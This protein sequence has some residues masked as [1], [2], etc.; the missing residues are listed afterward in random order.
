M[1][2]RQQ[3]TCDTQVMHREPLVRRL[4]SPEA[5][6]HPVDRVRLVETH[7]SWVFLTGSV[8]YKVKKPVN[9]GFLDFSTLEKRR[10]FCHEEVR[11]N[12]RFAPELYQAA[13][14][15]TGPQV[16]AEIAGQGTAIEWAVR[17]TQ[18]DESARLD[19]LLEAGTLSCDDTDRLARD[20]AAVQDHLEVAHQNT[21]WGTRETVAQT[22]G[23]NLDQLRIHRSAHRSRVEALQEWVTQ[24]I[25][26]RSEVFAQRR[27]EGRVRQCH[28]DLH[29]ANLVAH[30]GR[31]LAFDSIEFSDVLRWIDVA[32]DIAFLAMDLTSR[33]RHNL[34]AVVTS[35]WIEAS[36]DHSA[37]GVL[38][39][40]LVYRAI[41]RSAIAAI[42]GSQPEADVAAAHAESDRY[43]ALAE[44]LA[45]PRKPTLF[46]TCG[47][48]GCGKTTLARELVASTG[49][50]QLRSDV[51]RKRAF[52][53]TAT[54]RSA[55]AESRATLYSRAATQQTYERLATL[56]EGMLADG[57]TVVIDAACTRRWQRE[58][59]T[60]V[61]AKARTPLTWLA[62]QVPEQQ[63]Y[64]R[65]TARLASG[66]D[67]SDAS[68]NI[69]REQLATFEPITAD[70]LAM[71]PGTRM[72]HRVADCVESAA[73]T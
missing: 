47:V 3:T 40:Y 60:H 17:L 41:V 53:L 36:G 71:H 66:H 12:R 43:L 21:S 32:S 37:T 61:A 2:A 10:H 29:L 22:I 50:I 6:P 45:A 15:I 49:A 42:R 7:I 30:A 1:A 20:I 62:P 48:S 11:L 72:V 14:P 16:N 69:V 68:A 24:A 73:T 38:P 65:V 31:F 4:L 64:D 63:L 13:V 25:S 44:Q 57:A 5:Y 59:I 23:M 58:L 33:N 34:A 56:A 70:E 18:F 26:A 54:D 19:Q 55:S 35:S 28:G 27:H 9:L 39:I 51:E 52:G 46:A 8:V 67:A